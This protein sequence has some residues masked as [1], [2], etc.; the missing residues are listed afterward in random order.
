MED[1]KMKI[2]SLQSELQNHKL[3]AEKLKM[4]VEM[5]KQ[6]NTHLEQLLVKADTKVKELSNSGVN[7]RLI[8]LT[9]EISSL[10]ELRSEMCI[11]ETLN[12]VLKNAIASLTE[13]GKSIQL[14]N[15][16]TFSKVCSGFYPTPFTLSN[17]CQVYFK[18]KSHKPDFL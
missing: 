2:A 5:L 17:H 18:M 1:S 12:P 9:E 3:V 4:E 16:K 8:K 13:G 14:K 7:A 10:K 11:E 15:I 6:K